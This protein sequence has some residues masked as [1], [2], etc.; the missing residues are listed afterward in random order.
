VQFST[1]FLSIGRRKAM[2]KAKKNRIRPGR[3]GDP[4]ARP[5]KPP[6]DP[7]LAALRE[8][9]ILPVLQN[10]QSSEGK[11]RSMAATAVANM[12]DNDKC[13]RLLLRE[14]LVPIIM[15]NTLTDSSP[16]G[17]AAGWEILRMVSELED[18][19]FCV[20]LFR[21]D[22]LTAIEG[23]CKTV[24]LCSWRSP[25]RGCDRRAN[26]GVQLLETFES[27]EAPFD[28]MSRAQQA[29]V[30]RIS[31]ALCS[32][33]G[34][35]AETQDDILVAISNSG[36]ITDFLLWLLAREFIDPNTI[37]E[38]FSCMMTLTEDN[39]Q[40]CGFAHN[41]NMLNLLLKRKDLD[42][43][44]SVL[45]CGVL[46]NAFTALG[47]NDSRPGAMGATDK[48]L[49]PRLALTLQDYRIEGE[50]AANGNDWVAPAE[51]VTIALEILAA[52]A[53]SILDTLGMIGDEEGLDDDEGAEEKDEDMKDAD[54]DDGD[55]QNGIGDKSSEQGDGDDESMD[56]DAIAEDMER[57]LGND[58][59]EFGIDDLPTLEVFLKKAL[60][61]VLRLAAM[62]DKSDNERTI[63]NH[64]VS[65]L[66]N[67]A[68]SVSCV[69]FSKGR[70]SGLL[71]A[72]RPHASKIWD[73]VVTSVL[74][75]DTG[76]LEL[77]T[78]I[79]SLAWAL[80]R[81]LGTEV[82]LKEGQHQ[83]FISL[84]HAAKQLESAAANGNGAAEKKQS[85]LAD[86]GDP[87]QTLGVKCIGVLGQLAL[88]PAPVTLNRDVGV[89]LVTAVASLP[90][91]RAAEGIEALNQIFDIYA[92][93][94]AACD[95]E[96]FWKDGFLKHL[97]GCVPK[98]KAMLRGVHKHDE[99][100]REVRDR[101]EEVVMNLDRFITY[102]RKHR[103]SP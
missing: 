84:Y 26:M 21:L 57:V 38:L 81:V 91:T 36:R 43:T 58:N 69:D 42:G 60:P 19:G 24:S 47:W 10:L 53:T 78:E 73:L 28:R 6:A 9:K 45:V 88:P 27:K 83:K 35:L 55:E 59:D 56:D 103:P 5:S 13:R 70:N 75:S 54:I 67:I 17:R 23:A 7:E 68:W 82:P 44:T 76:D 90:T 33:V 62:K 64:A 77:A 93:E 79:T 49:I 31:T 37:D 41:T 100:T 85:P 66:N 40:I 74:N 92:D 30:W 80:A 2:G 16:D 12:I 71:R 102:K 25:D 94:E 20:H 48:E 46:H 1:K 86:D 29:I 61:Q 3:A 95:A 72:W 97:E 22:V 98:V 101:A 15:K 52:I 65:V 87:F 99:K 32:L 63:K 14:Q 89:F 18:S 51:I 11:T 96:V 4:L 50:E 39:A 8:Q 34:A